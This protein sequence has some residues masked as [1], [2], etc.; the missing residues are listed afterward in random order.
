MKK[1]IALMICSQ[2]LFSCKQI[3][4]SVAETFNPN[5]SV[6]NK[7]AQDKPA[8]NEDHFH[9]ETQTTSSTTVETHTSTHTEQHVE[10]TKTG[11][12]TNADQ[13]TKAENELKKLPQYLGKE[14]FIYSNINFYDDGHISV[15]LQHPQNPKYVDSYEYNAGKWSA[16][17]PKQLSVKDD[18]KSSLVSL[19]R[20]PFSNVAKVTGIY[21][22]KAAHIEGAKSSD[23]TYIAIFRNQIEW[24]PMNINGTRERYYIQFNPDGTL[25]E[26]KQD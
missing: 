11:F 15:M 13:L 17:K 14:I 5:D 12:L 26:F 25:K 24:Y 6:A 21:N 1:L 18:V 22:E 2:I 20:I 23:H 10:G 3:S 19:T 7:A 9:T 16:P 4:K 8:E